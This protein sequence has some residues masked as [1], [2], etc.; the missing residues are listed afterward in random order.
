MDKYRID[1]E[2]RDSAYLEEGPLATT[3]KYEVLTYPDTERGSDAE[4]EGF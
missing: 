2:H 1:P 4:D 3:S